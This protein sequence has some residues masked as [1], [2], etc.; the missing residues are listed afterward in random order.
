MGVVNVPFLETNSNFQG[1]LPPSWRKTQECEVM[2]TQAK[3]TYSG[4][5]TFHLQLS[6][7][8]SPWQRLISRVT[9][10]G[11]STTSTRLLTQCSLTCLKVITRNVPS[12][13]SP[14][15]LL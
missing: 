12:T 1:H 8:W 9:S 10:A 14:L 6:L 4:R 5:E 11:S 15:R 13:G 7:T 3:V 2:G